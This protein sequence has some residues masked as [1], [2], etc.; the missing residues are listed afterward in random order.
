MCVYVVKKKTIMDNFRKISEMEIIQILTLIN[1][2]KKIGIFER[3]H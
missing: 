3:T 2:L 1:M